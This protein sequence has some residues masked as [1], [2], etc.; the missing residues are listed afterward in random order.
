MSSQPS[1]AMRPPSST[2]VASHRISVPDEAIDDLRRRLRDTRLPE[3]ETVQGAQGPLAWAQGIPLAYVDELRRAWLEEHDWRRLESEINSYPQIMTSIDGVDIHALHVRSDRADARPLIITHGWPGCIVEALDVIDQLVNP[4]ADEPAFHLVLPSLPGY[5][6]SG[7]P[8]TPGWGLE[9]IADAWAELMS[10][11]G[12]GRFLA[13]GGDWG[14]MVTITLALRHPERVAMLHTTVPHALRP[15]G[16]SDSQLDD[17]E[18]RWLA[19]EQE[20]RRTGMGYA[21]IQSTRPQTIGYG[22]VDSPVALLA[23][24]VE[25]FYEASDCG[26]HPENAIS[27]QRLL[28]NVAFYW[29]TRSG[30]SSA[31]LYWENAGGAQMARPGLDMATPV[32]VPTGVSVFPRELRKLP[33][34]WVEQRFTN[35]R[36]WRVLDRGGHFPMLEVPDTFVAQLRA[37]FD[38]AE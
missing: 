16:F 37:A 17:V 23:W 25:K 19:E 34:S 32:A 38:A 2:E 28:D 5:G 29:M 21:A 26:G 35:L 36:Y 12:Y 11:L 9:R 15:E 13:Q 27:R 7:K 3:P 6:F 30:A 14:A 4:P 10:R 22:L 33:R 1:G 24:I 8:E 20:F 18:R 31:R